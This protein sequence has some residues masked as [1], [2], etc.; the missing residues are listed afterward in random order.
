MWHRVL[1]GKKN[2]LKGGSQCVSRERIHIMLTEN[3]RT[4]CGSVQEG[5]GIRSLTW[6]A[7]MGKTPGNSLQAP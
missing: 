3:I 7:Q 5:R 1:K 6:S 2:A 4:G